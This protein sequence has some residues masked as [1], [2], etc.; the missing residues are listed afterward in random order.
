MATFDFFY[1]FGSPYSYLA[2]TQLEGIEGR[3]GAKARLLPI[4][5]GGLRK[6]TGHQLPPPMQLKYMSEDTARWAKQ[7]GVQMRIPKV[8]PANSIKALRAAL[9]AERIGKQ[10]EAMGALF[11]TYWVEG[12]DLSDPA[13]IE[14]ALAQGGFDGK[15][16]TA[17]TEEDEIKGALRRNTSLALDR[18]VFGVPTIFVGERSFWGNDRLHFVESELRRQP[19]A[20]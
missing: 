1:D 12:N 4:T 8:F 6:T 5:L 11:H 17:A 15:A 18:G 14:S 7:Y 13:V 20:P 2:S 9:A 10:R 3:T 19:R 16:L